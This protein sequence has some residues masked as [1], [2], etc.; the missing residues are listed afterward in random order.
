MNLFRQAVLR[1]LERFQ[2]LLEQDFARMDGGNRLCFFGLVVVGD[3]DVFGITLSPV[4]A[5][6]P[7]VV[8]TDAALSRPIAS[9]FF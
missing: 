1:Q 5:N 9:E 3:F 8:D 6:S 7:L 4:K 2:V